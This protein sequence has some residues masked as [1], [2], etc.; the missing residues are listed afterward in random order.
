[1]DWIVPKRRRKLTSCPCS[2]LYL[3]DICLGRAEGKVEDI[4]RAVDKSWSVS[5]SWAKTPGIQEH[6]S[7]RKATYFNLNAFMMRST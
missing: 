4:I 3:S 6:G 1:M 7:K 5:P 2:C